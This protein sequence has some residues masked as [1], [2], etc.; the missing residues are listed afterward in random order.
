MQ[1]YLWCRCALTNEIR[2]TWMRREFLGL[3]IFKRWRARNN[4]DYLMQYVQ[5]MHPSSF[6]VLTVYARKLRLRH[7]HV[8]KSDLVGSQRNYTCIHWSTFKAF[9]RQLHKFGNE[10]YKKVT[11]G[12]NHAVHFKILIFLEYFF[13][14]I[15]RKF[16]KCFQYG[17]NWKYIFLFRGSNT[18]IK[19]SLVTIDCEQK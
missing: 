3:F 1:S 2:G 13:Q 4:K 11:K 15:L 17:W 8:K 10:N 5:K 16:V 18:T 14:D 12:L 7:V 6:S 9:N 19:K